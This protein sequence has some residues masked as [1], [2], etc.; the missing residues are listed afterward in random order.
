MGVGKIRKYQPFTPWG[1]TPNHFPS[2]YS[3]EIIIRTTLVSTSKVVV[4]IRIRRCES[5]IDP[6]IILKRKAGFIAKVGEYQGLIVNNVFNNIGR[7]IVHLTY[8][9][10]E[11]A[12]TSI[13]FDYR[14]IHLRCVWKRIS[15]CRVLDEDDTS[16]S[17]VRHFLFT[18]R[19]LIEDEDQATLILRNRIVIINRDNLTS[20]GILD[21]KNTRR[22][23][24]MISDIFP[25]LL[26]F[27]WFLK[28]N[29][30]IR[31][32]FFMPIHT[33]CTYG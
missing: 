24:A 9:F 6:D 2:Y 16:I 31:E 18:R 25:F 1:P 12:I 30:K 4:C 26:N 19:I 10:R 22:Y 11:V 33:F 32:R 8:Y 28:K 17:D 7:S 15:F 3:S 5:S 14:K 29:L 20:D 27:K 13:N 21:G 23:I